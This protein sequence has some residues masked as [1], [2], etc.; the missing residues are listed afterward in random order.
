MGIDA[1]TKLPEEGHSRPWP[2]IARM[3]E[4]VR[5]HIDALWPKLGLE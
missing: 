1:T 2:E 3:S 4:E 5:R